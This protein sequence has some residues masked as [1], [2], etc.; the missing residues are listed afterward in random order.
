MWPLSGRSVESICQMI[1]DRFAVGVTN[2]AR[3]CIIVFCDGAH[4]R[5]KKKKTVDVYIK[6]E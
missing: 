4:K 1:Y 2:S 3:K 6:I 5:L